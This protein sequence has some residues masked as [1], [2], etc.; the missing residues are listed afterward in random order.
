MKKVV[1]LLLSCILILSLISCGETSSEEETT[2]TKT[3]E[4]E[5]NVFNV[6]DYGVLTDSKELQTEKV[7]AVLDLCKAEGG[8][9]V[10]P[11]GTYYVASLYV[12]SNTTIHLAENAILYGS[13]EI[14][15]YTEF[16]IPNGME[17]YTNIEFF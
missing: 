7:Q 13:D 14:N 9:V 6:T 17:L 1:L 2:T 15:D 11:A 5:M 16:P 10:F 4:K 8:T 3:E 12:N